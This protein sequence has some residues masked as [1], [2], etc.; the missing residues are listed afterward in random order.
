MKRERALV[1]RRSIVLTKEMK[2]L[3]EEYCASREMPVSNFIRYAVFK[4]IASQ[5]KEWK[6]KITWKTIPE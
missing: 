3:L 1:Y 4:E 2:D 5:G 6:D